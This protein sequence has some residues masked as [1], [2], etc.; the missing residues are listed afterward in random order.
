MCS[1]MKYD[2]RPNGSYVSEQA[3]FWNR[4]LTSMKI[5]S[6]MSIHSNA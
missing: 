1:A 2:A 3:G 4:Q 6:D 5:S